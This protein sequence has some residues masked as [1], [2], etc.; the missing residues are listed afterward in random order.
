MIIAYKLFTGN[1]N[2]D[3]CNFFQISNITSRAHKLKI[4]KR[5]AKKFTRVH[6]FSNRIVNDWN[7]LPPCI[8][9]HFS[10]GSEN[11]DFKIFSNIS[12]LF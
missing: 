6:K 12:V 4:F 9:I 1:M 2:I 11:V 3:K 5:H 8:V 10:G 7:K